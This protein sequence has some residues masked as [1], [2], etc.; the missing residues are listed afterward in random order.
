VKQVLPPGMNRPAPVSPTDQ[1]GHSMNGQTYFD[2]DDDDSITRVERC[3]ILP[4]T[5]ATVS[6]LVAAWHGCNRQ[7][8][9]FIAEI[10]LLSALHH[11]CITTVMGRHFK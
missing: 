2:D 6:V 8:S 10:R 3:S 7:K 4:P 5:D 11:P 9:E 1:E